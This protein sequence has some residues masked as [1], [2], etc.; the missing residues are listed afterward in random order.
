MAVP[1]SI[2]QQ[3]VTSIPKV[4]HYFYGYLDL[5]EGRYVFINVDT[6]LNDLIVFEVN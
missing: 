1:P 2:K 4:A 5:K 3:N 6:N